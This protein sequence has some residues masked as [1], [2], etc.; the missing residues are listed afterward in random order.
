MK[1][2]LSTRMGLGGHVSKRHLVEGNPVGQ[3]Q[4]PAADER[5]R[6]GRTR[7]ASP[8]GIQIVDS[9]GWRLT[10]LAIDISERG[11]GVHAWSPLDPGTIVLTCL[12]SAGHPARTVEGSAEPQC[13]GQMLGVVRQCV[14]CRQGAYRLSIEFESR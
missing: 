8:V 2:H 1:C 13:A 12:E 9:A 4:P 3:E 14:P 10:G 11:I 7:I 5:R 6:I